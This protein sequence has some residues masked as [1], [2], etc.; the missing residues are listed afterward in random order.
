MILQ[1][2][3]VRIKSSISLFIIRQSIT[4]RKISKILNNEELQFKLV[5]NKIESMHMKS[6]PVVKSDDIKGMTT[7]LKMRF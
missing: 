2:I 5:Q 6:V 1:E 7:E 3:M 4:A